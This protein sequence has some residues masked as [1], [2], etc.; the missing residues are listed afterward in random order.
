MRMMSRLRISQR[1]QVYLALATYLGK[2][3]GHMK[4]SF[5]QL[6]HPLHT[7]PLLFH[8]RVINKGKMQQRV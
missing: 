1:L 7:T 6:L 3:N 8:L 2:N 5:L 4:Y